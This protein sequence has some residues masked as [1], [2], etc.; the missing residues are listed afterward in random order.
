MDRSLDSK[1]L[2]EPVRGYLYHAAPE[3][4]PWYK[5]VHLLVWICLTYIGLDWIHRMYAAF[6]GNGSGL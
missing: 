5:D 3:Q 1:H 4:T 6:T 2:S